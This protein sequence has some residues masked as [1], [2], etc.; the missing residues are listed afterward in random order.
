MSRV[1]EALTMEDLEGTVLRM[2]GTR[3]QD[4]LS[5]WGAGI[6]SSTTVGLD[7]GLGLQVQRT[8]EPLLD[9]RD[10]QVRAECQILT[11]PRYLLGEEPRE[12]SMSPH[13]D[14]LLLFRS[15]STEQFKVSIWS[16][17]VHEMSQPAKMLKGLFDLSLIHI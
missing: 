9:R 6:S 8:H 16:L 5:N 10:C 15:R 13:G 7:S 2:D 17:P 1:D 3:I 14:N 4:S 12:V 11:R